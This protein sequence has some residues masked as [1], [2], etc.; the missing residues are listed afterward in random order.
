MAYSQEPRPRTGSGSVDINNL[1]A[2]NLAVYLDLGH[3]RVSISVLPGVVIL[4]YVGE[5][6]TCIRVV[7]ASRKCY[8]SLCTEKSCDRRQVQRRRAVPTNVRLLC[9][10]HRIAAISRRVAGRVTRIQSLRAFSP[11]RGAFYFRVS[12]SRVPWLV[13][14]PSR[15]P[16]YAVAGFGLYHPHASSVQKNARMVP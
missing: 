9:C 10:R 4:G 2:W 8:G 3:K 13:Y 6:V 1:K 15:T 11:L 16:K 7:H 5:N 12:N 14:H